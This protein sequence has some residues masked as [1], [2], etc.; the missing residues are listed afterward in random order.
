[1]LTYEFVAIGP[2]GDRVHGTERAVDENSLDLELESRGM[3]L[4]T[5]KV[6]NEKTT[7]ASCGMNRD[8][9]SMFTTQLAT[10]IGAGLALIDGLEGIEERLKSPRAQNLIKH[11]VADLRAGES[12]SEAMKPFPGTF[13]IAYQA[14]VRAGEAAGSLDKVLVRL[15]S[16]L[17]WS[18][19]MRSTTMQALIYPAMLMVAIFGLILLLLFYVMPQLLSLFPKGKASLPWQTEVVLGVSDFIRDH[20]A[21]L[22]VSAVAIGGFLSVTWRRPAVRLALAKAVL[23]VPKLG[24]IAKQLAMSRFASTASTLQAAGCS[25]FMVLEVAADTCGNAALTEA[26]RRSIERVRQGGS[27][28][29]ALN[30]EPM[31]DPLLVQMVGVGERAG[32]LEHTLDQL[33]KYYD[34]EVPRAVKKFLSVLEPLLLV[35][36]GGIVAFILMAAILPLFELYENIG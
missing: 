9:L 12:L 22:A 19:S 25:V 6:V 17:E 1:M 5:S 35:G 13:P 28:S 34:D 32:A 30:K 20:A 10:V 7:V 27:I 36:A 4:T 26:F 24:G 11:M 18:R 31:I 21:L 29:E 2:K 23:G 14:S 15:A 33:A 16:F 8:E 3:V